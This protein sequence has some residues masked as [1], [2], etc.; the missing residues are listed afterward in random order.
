MG[1]FGR[2]VVALCVAAAAIGVP[3]DGVRADVPQVPTGT[4]T[5]GG[6]F[7]EIPRDAASAVLPDGRLVVSGGL[8]RGRA[9][10][11]AD[12]DLRSRLRDLAAGRDR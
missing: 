11:R 12:R 1:W 5:A 2:C 8:D 9:A 10:S 4:W 7:G 6:A 3:N